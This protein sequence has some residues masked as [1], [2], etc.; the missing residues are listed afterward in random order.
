MAAFFV[1]ARRDISRRKV[2]GRR[3]KPLPRSQREGVARSLGLAL[4]E[5]APKKKEGNSDSKLSRRKNRR[6]RS[7][8]E[9]AALAASIDAAE[10]C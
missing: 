2:D 6:F 5:M 9:Q 4:S 8:R 7:V 3:Y 10:E 1:V